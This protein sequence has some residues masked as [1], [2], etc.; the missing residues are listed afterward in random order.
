VT[1]AVLGDCVPHLCGP[2]ATRRRLALRGP[3]RRRAPTSASRAAPSADRWSRTLLA[4]DRPP[5]PS[6]STISCDN[7]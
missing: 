5:I 7:G 2:P 6:T 3:L 1:G 4:F